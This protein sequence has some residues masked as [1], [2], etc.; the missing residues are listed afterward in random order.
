MPNDR[1]YTAFCGL[2]CKDCIPG[3]ERLF[4]LLRDLEK[5]LIDIQFD[6]YAQLKALNISP[7]KNY[8]QFQEVL[9][10]MRK[11]ER[12]SLCTEG[13][14]KEDCK[15][16]KCVMGKKYEG[17]WECA[18]HKTCPLLQYL[19]EIHSIEHNLAMIRKYGPEGWSAYRGKHY[20]WL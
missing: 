10:E 20:C 3:N 14:C 19:K 6:E 11:L 8:P 12:K 9:G 1:K 2:Y 5:L 7:Y 4:Q 13:G 15:I 17:C 16:R 18:D